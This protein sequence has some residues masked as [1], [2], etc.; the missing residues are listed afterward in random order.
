MKHIR[1]L[2]YI[3]GILNILEIF[4]KHN[5]DIINVHMRNRGIK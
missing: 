2:L 4:N 1:G 5:F 3:S